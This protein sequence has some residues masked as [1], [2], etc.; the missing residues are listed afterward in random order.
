MCTS[1]PMKC[2]GRTG[3]PRPT[4]AVGIARRRPSHNDALKCNR[5]FGWNATDNTRD[6]MT[7]QLGRH[8]WR[9]S[10]SVRLSPSR[11]RRVYTR[12][13]RSI[14]S[15][16]MGTSPLRYAVQMRSDVS[17]GSSVSPDRSEDAELGPCNETHLVTNLL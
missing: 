14:K 4:P 15:E 7:V 17:L 16:E 12:Q 6:C 13:R 3:H 2:E 11:V 8:S 5:A 9:R 10:N 1:H